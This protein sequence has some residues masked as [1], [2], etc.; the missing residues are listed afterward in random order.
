MPDLYRGRTAVLTTKH[1]K[2]SSVAPPL[3]EVLGLTV[4]VAEADTDVLGTFTGEIPRTRPPQDTAVTKARL[5]MD[6]T[7]CPLGVA[8]EGSFV[9]HPDAP[10]ITVHTEL[11]VLVDDTRPDPDGQPLIVVERATTLDTNA[12][13]HTVTT[14]QLDQTG[15][16]HALNA[17]GFPDAGVIIR[18][19]GSTTDELIVKGICDRH[20]LDV[21][22]DRLRQES[23]AE[24]TIEADLRAHHNPRR[25]EVITRA[26]RGLATRLATSCPAC[27]TPGYGHLHTQPGLPC[28]ECRT[29]TSQTAASV[30]GCARCPHREHRPVERTSAS[31][32]HCPVCNP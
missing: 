10:W 5:G 32:A 21:A 18:C 19:S 9:A 14:D 13:R 16:D 4:T 7:G 24:I 26:A 22:L 30:H 8:T 31:P 25:R 12:Q 27:A 2:H 1:G 17:I 23:S 11:V 3:E 29:P 6:A 15:L 28:G 20:R